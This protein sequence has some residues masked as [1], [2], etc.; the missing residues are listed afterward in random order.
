MLHVTANQMRVRRGEVPVE[1]LY[2]Q[3]V[4][5]NAQTFAAV[6]SR[7][8]ETL[9]VFIPYQL[10]LSQFG[11]LSRG[12]EIHLGGCL[13]DN[14]PPPNLDVFLLDGLCNSF[15]PFFVAAQRE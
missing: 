6:F 10:L 4:S 8:D 14:L 13:C 1:S 5:V 7:D 2:R 9:L 3:C 11:N 12:E 15:K